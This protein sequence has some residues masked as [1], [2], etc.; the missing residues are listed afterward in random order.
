MP[1]DHLL[2]FQCGN[3]ATIEVVE[4][5]DYFI[6]LDKMFRETLKNIYLAFN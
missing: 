6:G 1:N 2:G 4:T 3:F 5:P